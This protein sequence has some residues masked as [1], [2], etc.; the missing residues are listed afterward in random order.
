MALEPTALSS[1]RARDWPRNAKGR[2][3]EA[4]AP[5]KRPRGI[6]A[7]EAVKRMH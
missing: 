7:P 5:K 1:H 6:R 4:D 2:R 3:T